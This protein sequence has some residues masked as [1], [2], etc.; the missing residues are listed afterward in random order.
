[1]LPHW[2]KDTVGHAIRDVRDKFV[3][4]YASTHPS[5]R[6]RTIRSHS[7]GRHAVSWMHGEGVAGDLGMEWA[8]IVSGRVYRGYVDVPCGVIGAAVAAA[9]SRNPVAG[10]LSSVF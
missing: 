7:G 9:D 8:R 6:D 2:S 5:L 3:E 1:M 4:K 10:D